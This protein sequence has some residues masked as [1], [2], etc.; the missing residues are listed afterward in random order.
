MYVYTGFE[1][2]A[3]ET[4]LVGHLHTLAAASRP[5]NNPRTGQQDNEQNQVPERN[6]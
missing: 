5:S 3:H 2:S 1:L 6:E 4:Q